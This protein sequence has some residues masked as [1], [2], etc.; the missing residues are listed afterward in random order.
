MAGRASW[1]RCWKNYGWMMEKLNLTVIH[2]VIFMEALYVLEK[3]N[4]TFK[5]M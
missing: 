3:V 4:S 1:K 5:E 2:L